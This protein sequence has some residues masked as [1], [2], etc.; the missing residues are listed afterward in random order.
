MSETSGNSMHTTK[1]ASDIKITVEDTEELDDTITSTAVSTSFCIGSD[2][3]HKDY[4]QVPNSP[5]SLDD[6]K[7]GNGNNEIKRSSLRGSIT[8]LAAEVF[9]T[10]NITK[11][12]K[13]QLMIVLFVTICL[14]IL[15]FVAP[16]IWYNI[17]LSSAA[18][19]HDMQNSVI[20]DVN[21][22][23]CSANCP[24]LDTTW[25]IGNCKANFTEFQDCA[26][27]STAVL[28]LHSVYLLGLLLNSAASQSGKNDALSFFCNATLLLCDGNSSSVDLT[29][30]CKEVR[31]N[32]CPS[33]WRI[34]ESI[35][36]RSVPDCVSYAKDGNLTFSKA[37][38][39]PCP[40]GFDHFCGSTC[41]PVCGEA[42]LSTADTS[43]YYFH[44][45]AATG[46]IFGLIVGAITMIVCY[47]NRQKL[48]RFPQIYIVYNIIIWEVYLVFITFP[49]VSH[50]FGSSLFCSDRNY[51]KSTTQRAYFCDIQGIV[52]QF[53][54]SCF[55]G[56]WCF[57]ILH[58][59]L[60]LAFPF[61]MKLWLDSPSRRKKI[62][63][64]EVTIVA[65]FGLLSPIIAV[66]ITRYQDNGWFCTPQCQSVAFYGALLP[67]IAVFCI[68]LGFLFT[69]LWILRK[70]RH[71]KPNN[72]AVA[73]IFC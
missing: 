1:F 35:C 26:L 49:L 37:P 32:K 47:Y 12:V 4:L 38:K 59:F 21:F 33:E 5:K 34:V 15:L 50:I 7:D 69:S 43:I 53:L 24:E 10:Q 63:I 25:L 2:E 18:S 23:S 6:T 52:L 31:D 17:N 56:S 41:L 65:L 60:G 54:Y 45:L 8:N 66:N 40:T 48:L 27:N 39:L 58:L 55:V 61:Q 13:V 71:L 67:D 46:G 70:K 20:D 51:L 72:I 57:H 36:N 9:T 22:E 29:E 14:M 11:V 64:T 42:F 28:G 19:C 73:K 3:L 44:F 62:H 16:I 68:G 30:E